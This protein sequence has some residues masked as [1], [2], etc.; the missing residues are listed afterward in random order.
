[1][2]DMMDAEYVVASLY[3]I[4]IV[5]V[6]NFWLINLFIAVITEMFAKVREDSQHSAFTNSTVKPVLADANDEEG[7]AFTE[8]DEALKIA[9]H[10]SSLLNLIVTYMKPFWILLVVVDLFCMAWKNNN[11]TQ[12]ELDKLGTAEMIFSLAFLFEI[13]LRLLNQRKDLKGFFKD[14]MNLTDFI[15]AIVTCIIQIP[16][17][18]NNTLV[19]I[20]FT[21]FQ[22]LRVYRL[23]VAVPRLRSL[24]VNLVFHFAL[25]QKL[26]TD[27]IFFSLVY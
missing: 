4:I 5:I 24:M 10:K 23:V 19:Y 17:I 20:W 8:R 16:D 12:E 14:R 25:F 3:F 11:M 1:M 18:R 15:I 9:R 13:L 27:I 26:I 21:G 22:V 6:M 7:W 2:Y